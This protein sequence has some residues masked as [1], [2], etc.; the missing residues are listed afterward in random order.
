LVSFVI[1]FSFVI[2]ESSHCCCNM[3]TGVNQC[4]RIS[5]HWAC[6]RAGHCRMPC[7]FRPR[8]MYV[9]LATVHFLLCILGFESLLFTVC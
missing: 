6:Y 1:S 2:A 5:S 7:C 9:T 4:H 8:N 3:P